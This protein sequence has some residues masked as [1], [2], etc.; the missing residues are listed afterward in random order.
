[1]D[2]ALSLIAIAIKA[3]WWLF[4]P[5]ILFYI[6][7]D[8]WVYWRVK[9]Y[10]GN[11]KWTMLEVRVPKDVLKTPKA[12]EF[13]LVGLHGVWDEL[14]FRDL[15]IKGEILPW[16]SLE[17][18][19][20]GG[21]VHFYIRTETKFR[22]LVE[23]KIYSQYPDAEIIEADDYMRQLFPP[24]IPN[25]DWDIW[26]TDL[27]L[28]KPSPYPLRNYEDFE[29]MVEE[30]R[31]DP[32]ASIAEG[33]GKLRPGEYIV[34]HI[35]ITPIMD[36][37]RNE[38]ERIMKELLGRPVEKKRGVLYGIFESYGKEFAKSF[39]FGG[40]ET[41]EKEEIFNLP[42][43]RLSPAEREVIKKIDEKTSKIAFNT[44][45][46]FMYIGRKD[47][48]SKVNI[49]TLFG[50]FRQFNTNNLNSFRP[51]SKTLPKRSFV[52]F[53]NMRT[54]IRKMRLFK[55]SQTRLK[56]PG[57]ISPYY[58]LSVDELATMYHFPGQIVKAPAL[59]RVESRKAPPPAGLPVEDLEL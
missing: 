38:G 55:Y 50:F 46:R 13:V 37:L 43:F 58:K 3:T 16:F 23:A 41:D 32:M 18:V 24:D 6:L 10:I 26:G 51:N 53:K 28:N 33:M 54:N 44:M 14:T 57:H 52:W 1:M 19:G 8:L 29:A 2:T 9:L 17:L 5:I 31:L 21:E 47:V 34:I 48:F 12:M 30:Q 39:G 7:K 25:K 35:M 56:L 45:I 4:T 27:K 22:N 20:Y 42:E 40:A 15:W 59:S 11:L 49:S 36:E